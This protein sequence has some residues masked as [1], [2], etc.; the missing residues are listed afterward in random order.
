MAEQAETP[1]VLLNIDSRAGTFLSP[2]AFS[3]MVAVME[4]TSAAIV[5]AD[6]YTEN[7]GEV[8]PT[9]CIDYRPGSL[10]D[11]FCFGPLVL[12]DSDKFRLAAGQTP[13]KYRYAGWYDVRLRMSR[14]GP[15]IHIPELLYTTATVESRRADEQQFDYVNPRNSEVQAEMELACTDHLKCI[16]A[17]LPPDEYLDCD[18]GE[19]FKVEASVIIPVRNRVNTIADAVNSALGQKCDFPFNVIVVDNHSTDGTSEVL[20]R[21]CH[22]HANLIVHTPEAT[23]LGIGGCWNEALNHPECGRFSIQL[24][25]DDLYA[26]ESV[27][28]DIVSV[29][30]TEQC[31]LVIGSYTITD[32]NLCQ[33]PPGLIAHNEWTDANGRNNALRINGFGAPRAFATAL[34]R[35]YPMPDVSYGEDYAMCLRLSRQYRVGRIFRSLYLCRR[36]EGNSDAGLDVERVNANN[37]YKDTLRTWEIAARRQIKQ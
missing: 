37:A 21:L 5:Y 36:W 2:Q 11:D 27:L 23:D 19:E 10:R 32:F 1:Y 31:G 16:G 22:G 17:Y 35:R 34:A 30:R 15:V 29:F 4:Q 14:M 26:S 20:A 25:S 8:H 9:P 3:R 12:L 7:S 24:D 33:L 18:Y 28:S 13:D 6:Y